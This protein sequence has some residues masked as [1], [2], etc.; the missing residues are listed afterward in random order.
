MEPRS[1]AEDRRGE[2]APTSGRDKAPALVLLRRESLIDE[3]PSLRFVGGTPGQTARIRASS[4]DSVGVIYES[5]AE[6]EVASSATIDP[7][8][9]RP[10]AG[11]YKGVDPFGLWWSMAS[12]AGRPFTRDL[13]PIA[14]TVT[15]EIDSRVVAQIQLDRLRVAP[16]V[17]TRPVRTEDL[18]ATLFLPGTSGP[19]PGVVVLGG[20]EGGIAQAEGLSALLASHGF[21]ALALAYFAME[22]L[23]PQLAEIPLEYLETAAR[24]LLRRP[25]VSP[26]GLG[27][28]GTSRGAELALLFA[29]V[30]PEVRAVVGFAASSVIWPG[31]TPGAPRARPAWTRGGVPFPF[32]LPVPGPSARLG[33]PGPFAQESLFLNGLQDQRRVAEAEIAVERI[34]GPVMLISGADDRMWPSHLLGELAMRRLSGAERRGRDRHLTYP[35]AGH[36]VGRAPGLPA[37][38]TTIVDQRNGMSHVLGGSRAGNARS[39]RHSWPRVLAFLAEHLAPSARRRRAP[40]RRAPS[41]TSGAPRTSCP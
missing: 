37:A 34:Q 20:S 27:M 9:Q 40:R 31:Y 41:R 4:V 7:A 6:Y 18:V 19:F 30:C 2:Q 3:P 23:P 33:G 29:S 15:A 11:T 25:E 14:T 21:A 10:R 17:I 39:A 28:M 1:E 13:R 5:W 24:W 35:G 32:A 26:H 36:A 8:R 16:D 12:A 22:G 38:A